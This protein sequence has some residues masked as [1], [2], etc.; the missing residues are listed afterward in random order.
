[1]RQIG[2]AEHEVRAGL[3]NLRA[4]HHQPEV[5]RLHV[6]AAHF[7]AVVQRRLVADVMAFQAKP[8]AF[9]HFGIHVVHRSVPP[10]WFAWE[11]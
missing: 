7:E 9:L 5:R 8:D 6:R 4:I 2:S 3:A 11:F 10:Q 1:M